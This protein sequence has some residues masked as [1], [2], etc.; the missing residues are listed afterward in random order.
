MNYADLNH[1]IKI[2]KEKPK[3]FFQKESIADKLQCFETIQKFGSPNTIYF[4]IEFLRSDSVLIQNK[5]AETILF[6]FGKLTSLNDYSGTLKH[7]H[8]EK[9]DLDFY[10]VDFDENTYVQLL[11]IASLNSSGYVREK[12]VKELSRLKKAAGLKF[13]LLRLGDW[14]AEVRKVATEGILS[15]LAT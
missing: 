7:L 4:L 9:N 6:L 1:C 3:W 5:A 13:I 14:V 12:A 8:I 15:F 11:G 2:L 10:R